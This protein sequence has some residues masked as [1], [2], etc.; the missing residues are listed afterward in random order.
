MVCRLH[1][2]FVDNTMYTCFAIG[3]VF[4]CMMMYV[5]LQRENAHV[6]NNP[7]IQWHLKEIKEEEKE[8]EEEVKLRYV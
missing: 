5:F 2:L 4:Y 6:T 7:E 3:L 8:F 1:S